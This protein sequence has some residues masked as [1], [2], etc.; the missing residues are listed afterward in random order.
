[1]KWRILTVFPTVK[2]ALLPA[3]YTRRSFAFN[4]EFKYYHHGLL[5]KYPDVLSSGSPR[6]IEALSVPL[7]THLGVVS[8]EKT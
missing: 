6:T 5:A 2:S 8:E 3:V 7:T 1:M 4:S